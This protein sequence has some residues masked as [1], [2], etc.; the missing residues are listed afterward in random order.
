VPTKIEKDTVTG[1][2]T[3]GHEWDGVKELNRPLPKWWL[4]L[5][6]ASVVWAIGLFVLY[7]AIPGITGYFPGLIGYSQRDDVDRD[8]AKVTAQRAGHMDRIA[9]QPFPAIRAD[10]QLYAV[11]LTAGRIAFANNCQP[12][13]GAG[14]EGRIGYPALGDDVWLW[15]GSHADIQHSITVGIRAE[16]AE[17]RASIMPTYGA[18]LLQPAEI[19]AVTDLVMSMYGTPTAGVDLVAGRKIYMEN[20]VDCHGANGEGNAEKGG[21][22]LAARV[23][24]LGADRDRVRRQVAN[25]RLGVMPAWNTRLDPATIK[26]LTLYVHQL[27]GGQ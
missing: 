10:G 24:L 7:P 25:P 8:V 18:G 2:D 19:D 16:H 17:T 12:C 3:T 26:A 1:S 27:G 6:I 15:G 11:A 22:R 9:A 14:G 4:Y 5:Y 13:H 21:P 20:C 23:H